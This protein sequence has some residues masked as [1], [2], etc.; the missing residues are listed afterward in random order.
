[1]S[2]ILD[3]AFIVGMGQTH[4]MLASA[5][6]TSVPAVCKEATAHCSEGRCCSVVLR[7]SLYLKS[8][9]LLSSKYCMV[10]MFIF[11]SQGA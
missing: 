7:A 1:M 3:M 9:L 4:G 10:E 2:Q 8:Q 6:M 11:F 5:Q